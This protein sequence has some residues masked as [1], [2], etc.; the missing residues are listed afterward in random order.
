MTCPGGMTPAPS[1]YGEGAG[2]YG[3]LD[4]NRGSS[5]VVL[6]VRGTPHPPP[7]SGTFPLRTEPAFQAAPVFRSAYSDCAP[8]QLF[9]LFRRYA[10]LILHKQSTGLF[11]EKH[12]CSRAAPLRE[13][14][15]GQFSPKRSTSRALPLRVNPQGEGKGA[16]VHLI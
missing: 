8:K 10:W 14:S 1:P 16:M 5:G 3:F 12:S 2:V 6:V 15:T 7:A 9:Q 11:M 13:Q 4:G